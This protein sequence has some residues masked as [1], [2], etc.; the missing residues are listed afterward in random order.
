MYPVFE[1]DEEKN[2]QNIKKHGFD[3]AEARQM[4]LGSFPLLVRLDSRYDYN[5]ARWQGIG[6]IGGRVAVVV[7]TQRDPN[8][9]RI[10]SLRKANK[11]ERSG[12]K[13]EI[14]D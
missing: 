3:F 9:I 1:W 11:N 5:E 14:K 6:M 10:I 13:G 7:F 12:Y 8:I 4:F 2:E